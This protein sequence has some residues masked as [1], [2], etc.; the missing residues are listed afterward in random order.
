[1]RRVICCRIE[2]HPIFQR[3]AWLF[4]QHK[5]ISSC[6]LNKYCPQWLVVKWDPLKK[7]RA[8]SSLLHFWTDWAVRYP[9]ILYVLSFLFQVFLGNV[10]SEQVSLFIVLLASFFYPHQI[11]NRVGGAARGVSW[12][13][14]G[15]VLNTLGIVL[16]LA[17][18]CA[19]R[20]VSPCWPLVAL[21]GFLMTAG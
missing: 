21:A 20:V 17:R 6:T 16:P 11:K 4:Q 13:G 2:K 10:G 5:I 14:T 7:Q 19:E 3:V 1:M 8:W 18:S 9:G 12:N 15:P